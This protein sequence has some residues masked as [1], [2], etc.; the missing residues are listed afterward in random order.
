[1]YTN[2]AT[3]RARAQPRYK[4]IH[5]ERHHQQNGNAHTQHK[6]EKDSNNGIVFGQS[7]KMSYIRFLFIYFV[8]SSMHA[9]VLCICLFGWIGVGVES[10]VWFLDWL[11]LSLSF[12]P[13]IHS[14]GHNFSCG[15]SAA[16]RSIYERVRRAPKILFKRISTTM[17]KRSNQAFSPR[18]NHHAVNWW[19]L[20]FR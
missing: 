13:I 5:C 7:G 12:F 2:K 6:N 16:S 15:K 17:A 1:M 20:S 3:F 9:C 10:G 11:P 14:F 4:Y 19:I 18:S 8:G